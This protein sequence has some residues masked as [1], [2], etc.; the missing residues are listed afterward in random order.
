MHSMEQHKQKRTS[1]RIVPVGRVYVKKTKV[2]GER[3]DE[4]L[5]DVPNPHGTALPEPER[6]AQEEEEGNVS[7]FVKGFVP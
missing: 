7:G 1:L 4:N 5:G 3:I 6:K 2:D